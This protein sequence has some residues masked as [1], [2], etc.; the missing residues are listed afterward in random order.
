MRNSYAG[1]IRIRFLGQ[2][3][4]TPNLSQLAPAPR[5]NSLLQ[6]FSGF[7]IGRRTCLVKAPVIFHGKIPVFPSIF[8]R[9]KDFFSAKNL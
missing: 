9:K 8:I 4:H 3:G 7:I 5:Y 6:A 1:I 2:G